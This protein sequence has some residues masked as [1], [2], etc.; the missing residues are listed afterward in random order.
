MFLDNI[1]LYLAD[2]QTG[3]LEMRFVCHHCGM[4][5]TGEPKWQLRRSHPGT[6]YKAM[7]WC[8]NDYCYEQDK[9]K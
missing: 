8:N 6:H 7:F 5:I 9:E 3:R 4:E 1:R 2:Q